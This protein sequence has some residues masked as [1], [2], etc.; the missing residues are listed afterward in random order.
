MP[1][2]NPLQRLADYGQS[3]WND[4]LSREM[5]TSGELKRLIAEDG[6]VGIT[7]NPTIFD[8]AISQSNDYDEQIKELIARGRNVNEIY[9]AL[10]V[11]DIQD[12][13]DILRPVHEAT[14]GVDGMV[15]LEVSPFLAHNTGR[16]LSEARRLNA[17]VNRPNVMIKIPGTQ[18]GIPAIE[19][20]LY[21]GININITLL[22]SLDAY[23]QVMESYLRAMERRVNEGKPVDSITSVASFFVSRVDSEVDKRL[24]A[25]ID[26]N[27]QSDRAKTAKAIMG[28]VA[29]ANARLAYQEFK[30]VFNSDRFAQLAGFGVRIQRPLWASTS[31]KNP[32]YSDT[33]YI[34]ELIGPNTVQTMAPASIEAFRDHGTVSATVEQDVDVASDTIETMESLGIAYQDVIDV[35]VR[36]GVEKF[37]DSFRSLLN[38]LERVCERL[39]NEM[40]H[41]R[42]TR[43][44]A[45]AE[46]AEGQLAALRSERAAKRLRDHDST[47]WHGDTAKIHDRLGWL[48]SVDEMLAAAESG[49]FDRLSEDTNRRGYQRA[50]L[51]G[52]GGSSLAPEVMAAILPAASGYPVLEVLDTTNPDAVSAVLARAGDERTLFIVSSKSGTTIETRALFHFF[53]DQRDGNADDFIVVTDPG[54]PLEVE[55]R[56][57]GCW[58]VFTN[59][60][61]IGG[62]YSALSYFGLV[63][64]TVAGIDVKPLLKSAAE[65]IPVHNEAHPGVWIGAALAGAHQSGRD[66]LTILADDPWDAF[67]DWLEQLIAESTG[68]QG[69]G[70]L[71]VVREKEFDPSRYGNDRIFVHIGA[72]D[73]PTGSLVRDIE[74]AGHPVIQ[75]HPDLGEL[76]ITWEIATAIAGHGLGINPF[77][78]PNVQEAKDATNAVLAGSKRFD[79]AAT[80]ASKALDSILNAASS[81]DYVAILAFVNPTDKHRVAL[82]QLR[83]AVGERTGLATTVGIG[84]R[85]LHSTG[86]LHKGGATNGVFLQLVQHPTAE[87]DIPGESFSFSDLFHAQADGDAIALQ[88]HGRPFWRI[89]VDAS[90]EDTIAAM[91]ETLRA[92]QVNA[93]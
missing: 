61:D 45:V 71:P 52:M 21:E 46:A 44:A 66:K 18:E 25:I 16:T 81:G 84:P 91:T 1:D 73:S 69:V 32:D 39:G 30:K 75:Q 79:G 6:V 92:A 4:N 42:T 55:A 8:Q 20:A 33:L 72:S 37:A 12:A 53:L 50:M 23:R 10:T 35:L 38:S 70:I 28:R 68:K 82:D 78:E 63:P 34:D 85:Y 14:R 64:A 76:F 80:P 57:R 36:E 47:F 48:T 9:D 15:S 13:C 59:R 31:T 5:I 51:L 22:F 88:Q 56:E 41:E 87:L 26:E 60:P 90:L 65:L 2:R 74:A 54:S 93:D 58:K 40:H 67:G 43:L 24:Q 89:D 77:D 49:V 29:I 7:S 62:R 3:V 83:Q 19:Q 86:Q 11:K 17:L 27:P